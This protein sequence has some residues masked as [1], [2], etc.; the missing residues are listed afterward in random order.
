MKNKNGPLAVRIK[1]YTKTSQTNI[2]TLGHPLYV[3]MM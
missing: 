1:P 3:N 2:L